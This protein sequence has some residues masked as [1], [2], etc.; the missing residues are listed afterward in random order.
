MG[1]LVLR[2]IRSFLLTSAMLFEIKHSTL[3]RH[4]SIMIAG[5]RRGV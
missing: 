2:C 4:Q 3:S 1:S 5:N